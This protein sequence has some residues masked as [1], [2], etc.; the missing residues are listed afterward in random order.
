M[1]K[2]VYIIVFIILFIFLVSFS[3]CKA[4]TSNAEKLVNE[5]SREE[6]AGAKNETDDLGSEIGLGSE[7]SLNSEVMADSGLQLKE[8]VNLKTPTLKLSIYKGPEYAQDGTICFYRIKATVTGKPKPQI[9]FSRDNSNGAW[10]KNIAQVNLKEG[11]SYTLIC[12]ATNSAGKASGSIALNW[13]SNQ[14]NQED[15]IDFSDSKNFSIDVDLTKQL[16][17]VYYKDSILKQMICSSGTAKD[18]TPVGTFTTNQKIYYSW[19]S[20]FNEGAYYW[21]RFYGPYLLHS[22]PFDKNG[23]IIAEESS[24][25]G[26]PASHGCIRLKLEEAMWLY[27]NLPLGVKVITHK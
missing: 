21:V 12:E 6:V 22:V 5:S 4:N 2:K 16:V 9:I 11:E 15:S 23:N 20:K 7:I 19:I 27:K 8:A 1:L 13:V 3:G 26:T 10:G 18:P 25:L 14:G 24:K 17:T